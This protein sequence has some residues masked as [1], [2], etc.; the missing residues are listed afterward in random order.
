MK[1]ADLLRLLR[2]LSLHPVI[3]LFSM[4]SSS[5]GRAVGAPALARHGELE[6]RL[7]LASGL[8]CYIRGNFDAR[9]VPVFHFLP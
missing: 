5:S 2:L 7:Q 6:A 9:S 1:G 3:D 8:H 4:Q